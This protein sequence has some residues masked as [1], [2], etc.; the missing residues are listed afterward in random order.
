MQILNV[1]TSAARSGVPMKYILL[2]FLSELAFEEK[3]NYFMC[4]FDL[5][6]FNTFILY[7]HCFDL[8]LYKI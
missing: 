1:Q 5:K 6:R 7:L 4:Y 2:L 8:K 3:Q